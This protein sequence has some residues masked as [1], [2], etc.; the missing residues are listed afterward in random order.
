LL[1][2]SEPEKGLGRDVK[3][4]EVLANAEKKIETAFRTSLW[5]KQVSRHA[6]SVAFGSL[7]QFEV[8]LRHALR[9]YDLRLRLIGPQHPDTLTSMHNLASVLRELGKLDEAPVR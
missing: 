7:G 6:L 1:G 9:S 8:A 2:A 4:A 5:W 3:V